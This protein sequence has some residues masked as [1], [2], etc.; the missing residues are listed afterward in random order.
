MRAARRTAQEREEE[1]DAAVGD[2]VTLLEQKGEFGL[3]STKMY[4]PYFHDYPSSKQFIPIE[5]QYL[6]QKIIGASVI[7][8]MQ[9][10]FA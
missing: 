9:S 7:V 10:R 4:N 3:A 6:I 5:P 2:L 1:E 8:Q